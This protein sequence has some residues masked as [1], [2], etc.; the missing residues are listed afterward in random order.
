MY[1]IILRALSSITAALT[2]ILLITGCAK[3]PS[4]TASVGLVIQNVSSYQDYV[5]ASGSY[6][7]SFSATVPQS[8]AQA[9]LTIFD[10]SDPANPV[11]VETRDVGPTQNFLVVDDKLVGMSWGYASDGSPQDMSV[12]VFGLA[13]PSNPVFEKTIAIPGTSG[14][15]GAEFKQVA[16]GTILLSLGGDGIDSASATTYVVRLANTAG[17]EV[18]GSSNRG[19]R[20]AVG[21]SDRIYCFAAVGEGSGR[22]TTF[23]LSPLGAL[24]EVSSV[25]DSTLKFTQDAQALDADTVLVTDQ[26]AGL[27]VYA[28][29]SGAITGSTVIT[30]ETPDN[31]FLMSGIQGPGPSL[32]TIRTNEIRSYDRINGTVLSS[33]PYPGSLAPSSVGGTQVRLL[34][35]N[36]YVAAMGDYGILFFSADVS[37][38]LTKLGG[39]YRSWFKTGSHIDTEDF[40]EGSY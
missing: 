38:T 15:L 28:L 12:R 39:Y 30:A 31:D 17:T 27:V 23:N 32:V 13:D 7:Y 11:L 4:A 20:E 22:V 34:S 10:A 36:T 3:D 5:Y 29:S 40:S 24:S 9:M 8:D 14:G 16:Q 25:A 18:T 26:Y 2:L 35:G 33:L 6:R 37:G 19:C 1:Q 21:V